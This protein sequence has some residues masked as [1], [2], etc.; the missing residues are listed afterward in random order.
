VNDIGKIVKNENDTKIEFFNYKT[1]IELAQQIGSAII[2][3]GLY[4]T[5]EG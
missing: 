4:N 2:G 5:P 1:S 3:Q